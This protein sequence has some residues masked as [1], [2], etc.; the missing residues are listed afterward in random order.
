MN[1]VY[2]NREM[3]AF[4]LAQLGQILDDCARTVGPAGI[5]AT[6][7]ERGANRR[8]CY[9]AYREALLPWHRVAVWLKRCQGPEGERLELAFSAEERDCL[10]LRLRGPLR[11][12][13]DGRLGERPAPLPL[14]ADW[15]CHPLG[16][17][18]AE[19]VGLATLLSRLSER[20]LAPY[21]A[22]DL[23]Q[24]GD[25]AAS[26]MIWSFDNGEIHPTPLACCVLPDVP[27]GP[28][29]ELPVL[30]PARWGGLNSHWHGRLHLHGGHT[31][32]V[33]NAAGLFGVVQ[34][35][36]LPGSA[37]A[38]GPVVGVW[39]QS[40]MWP[41]L[42]GP[43]CA[44]GSLLEAAHSL[45][46]DARGEVLCDL[47]EPLTGLRVNPP[48]VKALV[49]SLGSQG[50]LVANEDEHLPLRLGRVDRRGQLFCGQAVEDHELARVPWGVEDLR[51][52]EIRDESYGLAAVRCP[53]T[54]LWGYVGRRGEV[55]IAPAFARVAA[56]SKVGAV[57]WPEAGGCCG[58]INPAGQ[59][60]LAPQ[61]Q[62]IVQE[63]ERVMVV[64]DTE[65]AWGAVSPAGEVLMALAPRASWVVQ[66]DI[67]A[68]LQSV[69]ERES[70]W[71]LDR[72]KL[73]DEVIADGVAAAWR[74]RWRA[75]ICAAL[76]SGGEN[77]GRCVG[78][79]DAA[80]SERDLRAVGL[81]GQR[82]RLLADKRDGLLR[83]IVGE[84][85]QI[86]AYYPVG[87]SCFDLRVEA[88]VN[89][90]PTQPEAA[91][92]IPWAELALVDL[93]EGGA[94]HMFEDE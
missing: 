19:D 31:L 74:R 47:L 62:R 8:K 76:A 20:C 93:V 52:A 21:D 60:L 7:E 11:R 77:L 57:V 5:V 94:L 66:P 14:I 81:W 29:G 24:V 6:P 63:S 1:S 30:F 65:D 27:I 51:W 12:V 50:V 3:N 82:V 85:G 45:V 91:I 83:P 15:A 75:A 79:F 55:L 70:R 34:L 22:V 68:A 33:A 39:M 56:F 23:A 25:P 72:A 26:Q 64:Q 90:L 73:A 59:W 89:G 43:K 78:L 48:G 69:A 44:V 86:G 16:V 13:V 37:G 46:P 92:G 49:G 40:C 87:L 80:T 17:V 67:A 36:Q 53:E 61:W 58:L 38:A 42:A 54:G 41:W 28:Q 84:V 9:A 4:D 32:V 88:P 10:R 18:V 35:R 2:P 71:P